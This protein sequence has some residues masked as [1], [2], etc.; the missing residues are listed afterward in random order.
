MCRSTVWSPSCTCDTKVWRE[1]WRSRIQSTKRNNLSSMSMVWGEHVEC[2]MDARGYKR[3]DKNV[4]WGFAILKESRKVGLPRGYRRREG[5]GSRSVDWTRNT[6]IDW[7]NDFL[8]ERVGS[9]ES[10]AWQDWMQGVRKRECLGFGLGTRHL[11]LTRLGNYW[12]PQLYEA[13]MLWKGF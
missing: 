5:M 6:W 3:I 2:W 13:L 1:K 12:L 8:K 4:S 11:N 7:V 9:E 10:G